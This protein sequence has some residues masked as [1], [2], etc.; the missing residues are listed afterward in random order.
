MTTQIVI[1]LLLTFLINLIATISYSV[2]P[3]P[4]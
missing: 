2:C 3:S 4:L 1:V